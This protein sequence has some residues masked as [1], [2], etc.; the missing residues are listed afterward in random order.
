MMYRCLK[1]KPEQRYF[2]PKYK[3]SPEDSKELLFQDLVNKVNFLIGRELIKTEAMGVDVSK[4]S[5]EDKQLYDKFRD[6]RNIFGHSKI[7]KEH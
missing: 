2:M 4:L 1:K 7:T 6:V 3:R 5:K